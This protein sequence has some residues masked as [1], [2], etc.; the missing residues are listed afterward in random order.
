MLHLHPKS[1]ELGEEIS[2][3]FFLMSVTYPSP[4]EWPQNQ[5]KTI[6][7]ITKD[8]MA[9]ITSPSHGFTSQDLNVTSMTFK[10]VKGMLQI[11]GI[12]SIVSEVIDANH[13]RVN[14]NSTNFATYASGGVAIV[15]TGIPPMEQQGNQ[16]FNTP[17][18]N[19]FP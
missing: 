3:S 14:V 11:N 16:F 18:Q 9:K 8:S 6:A 1:G 2:P 19:T 13:F 17:F 12:T 4:L 15:D 7:G 5:I 10:Q